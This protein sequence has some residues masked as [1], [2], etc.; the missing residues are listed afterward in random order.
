MIYCCGISIKEITN[1]WLYNQVFE[2][3][4]FG[5][6]TGAVLGISR[7]YAENIN[8]DIAILRGNSKSI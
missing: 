6:T 2:F 4:I 7:I 1:Y 5:T 8:F 3:R